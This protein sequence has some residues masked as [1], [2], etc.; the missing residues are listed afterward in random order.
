MMPLVPTT[1]KHPSIASSKLETVVADRRMYPPCLALLNASS[2][3]SHGLTMNSRSNPKFPIDL[4]I[5][6][7]F[8]SVWGSTRTILKLVI[9]LTSLSN[10]PWV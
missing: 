3:S 4:A 1:K 6:P 9:Y 2:V 10:P 5:A 8:P 7:T